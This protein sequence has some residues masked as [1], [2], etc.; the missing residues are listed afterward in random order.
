VPVKHG[1]LALLVERPRHGYELKTSFDALTGG[2]WDLNIG[3]VYSTL[4]RL[5]REGLVA[6]QEGDGSGEERKVYRTTPAG[7]NELEAWLEAPP[8][9]ARPFRDEIFVRL[10]L[11]MDRDLPASLDLIDTQSRVYHLQ[12]ADLTRQKL[13]LA[14]SRALDRHRLELFLDAALLHAEADLK[15]LETCEEKI[16]AW[17]A[18]RGSNADYPPRTKA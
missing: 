10:A 3:Q 5:R 16:R 15:W 4:E 13:A 6:L 1:I 9:E 12:M 14:R 18:S 2:L 17:A 8:L 11:L 7:L